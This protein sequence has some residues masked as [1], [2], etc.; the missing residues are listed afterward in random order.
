MIA[1]VNMVIYRVLSEIV[2]LEPPNPDAKAPPG[3]DAVTN[4]FIGYL[5]WGGLVAGVVGLIIIGIIMAVGRRN[6]SNAS[7]EAA[8]GIPWV[9]GGLT[10]ISFAAALVGT[11][12]S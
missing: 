8:A 10:L 9:F 4:D 3:V 6:R 1:A 7:V 11:V 5:K 2:A 12:L